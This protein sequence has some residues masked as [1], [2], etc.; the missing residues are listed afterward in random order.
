[1]PN[2]SPGQ[3]MTPKEREQADTLSESAWKNQ[4]TQQAVKAFLLRNPGGRAIPR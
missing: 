2:T 1:M 3:V 4:L